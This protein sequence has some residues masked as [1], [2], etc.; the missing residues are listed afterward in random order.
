MKSKTRLMKNITFILCLFLL[1]SSCSSDDNDNVD[2]RLFGNWELIKA[3][4]GNESG[5]LQWQDIEDGYYISLNNNLTYET[6]NPAA[7]CTD[8]DVTNGTYIIT[9]NT[10][11]YELENIITVTIDNCTN[12]P[13]STVEEFYFYKFENENL[14]L[15][16]RGSGCT[17]GCQYVFKK[18]NND[19]KN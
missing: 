1:L 12:G 9:E 17:E 18:L 2:T 15:I 6:N 7:A 5:E 16:P 3:G 8:N 11:E 10:Q 4:S 19:F 13:N 14:I